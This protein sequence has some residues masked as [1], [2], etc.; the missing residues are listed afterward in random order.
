MLDTRRLEKR[1]LKIS[2]YPR[3]VTMTAG[4]IV[5]EFEEGRGGGAKKVRR[6]EN[7]L[8]PTCL[9]KSRAEKEARF[10]PFLACV[11]YA[12]DVGVRNFAADLRTI[13][14]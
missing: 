14:C 6:V 5:P 9:P 3:T 8:Y 11:Y 10:V 7:M 12:G 4:G 13:A 1:E 2:S